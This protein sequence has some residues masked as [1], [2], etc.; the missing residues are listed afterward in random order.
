MIQYEQQLANISSNDLQTNQ[1]SI[2]NP[3]PV[4]VGLLLSGIVSSIFYSG[5]MSYTEGTTVKVI[6][7]RSGSKPSYGAQKVLAPIGFAVGNFIAGENNC[8]VA[9]SHLSFVEVE[10]VDVITTLILH[11]FF[12]FVENGTY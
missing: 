12:K 6:Y 9:I 10:L 8:I 2:S 3:T 4:F 5:V 11:S 1:F 7:S